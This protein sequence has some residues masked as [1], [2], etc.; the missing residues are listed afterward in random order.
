[1][2]TPLL[3]VGTV[4]VAYFATHIAFEWIERRFLILS[5]AEYLVLGIILGPRVTGI[6]T[7]QVLDEL[8]IVVVVAT[9]WIGALVGLWFH[10]PA[11]IR[12]RA[13]FY[14]L[15]FVE[16]FLTCAF[17]SAVLYVAMVA[18]TPLSQGEAAIAGIAL[19][20]IATIS[21][22]ETIQIIARRLGSD[23]PAVRHLD[24][25]TSINALVGIVI[26]AFLLSWHH[27][28]VATLPR[29]PTT[30]EWMAINLA[31]GIG[32][33]SLFHL[34][35]AGEANVDRLVVALG[36]AILF[37]GGAAEYLGLSPMLACLVVSFML[38]NTS[39]T[40]HEVE[41]TLRRIERP[42]Y[43]VLLI[44]AG[45]TWSP[46]LDLSTMGII[47]LFVAT[48]AA[49]RVGGA[50][51]AARLLGALPSA[52]P[53]WGRAL[54]GQ[55]ALALA[56]GLEYQRSAS[57]VGAQLVLGA[58]VVSVLLTDLISVRVAHAVIEASPLHERAVEGVAAGVAKGAAAEGVA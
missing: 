30:T 31:L 54:L 7:P 39:R 48:R 12:L 40:R 21:A 23:S 3:L 33:G 6:V 5:G 22:S 53:Q 57:A 42:L 13:L 28:P 10:L 17:V 38:V 49:A 25:A 16:S 37:A 52:G 14:K 58:V 44:V 51:L 8:S 36:G 1:M 32:A 11:M 4:I 2:S 29:S 20:A 47:A 18:L 55:G 43:F 41:A 19:G 45:A 26:V 35:L 56:L 24:V 34:F 9:A 46:R 27:P 50:R 15:A